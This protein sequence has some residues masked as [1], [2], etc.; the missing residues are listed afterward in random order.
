MQPSTIYQSAQQPGTGNLARRLTYTLLIILIVALM[1]GGLYWVQWTAQRGITLGYPHPTVHLSPLSSTTLLINSATA[2]SANAT[3]RGLTYSWDFGDGA[4]AAG[5]NVNHSYQQNGSFTVT[6]T[7]TDAL[8]QTNSASTSVQVNPPLPVASFT[9]TYYGYGEFLFD[10]SGSSADPSTSIRQYMWD[11][12]DG[13]S[14][15]NGNQQEYYTYGATGQTYTVTLIVV[16]GTGQQ[17]NPYT[18][19]VTAS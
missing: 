3:G 19:T 13:N 2:F 10:A 14:D 6:V 15:Q 12:G 18:L 16:D 17:S 8:G 11:F 4:T 5:A 9:F 1:A 7:V